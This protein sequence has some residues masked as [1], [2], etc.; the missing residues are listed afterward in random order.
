M[1]HQRTCVGQFRKIKRDML[2]S[3]VVLLHETAIPHTDARTRAVLEH[4]NWEL[5]DHPRYSPDIAPSYYRLL[6]YLK[7]SLI[8]ERFGNSVL[9]EVSKSAEI[10]G[11]SLL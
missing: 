6:I 2:T 9:M 4:F 8:S 10:I 1:K 11:G 7:N 3:G 5:F